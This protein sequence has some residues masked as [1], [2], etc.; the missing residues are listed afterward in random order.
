[1]RKMLWCSTCF[2]IMFVLAILIFSRGAEAQTPEKMLEKI[3][4]FGQSAVKIETGDNIIYIDPL[5]SEKTEDADIILITHS[6]S[7]H[8][9]LRS[10]E[11]VAKKETVF[12]ATKDCEGRIK[13]KFNAQVITLKPGMSKDLNGTLIEAVPAYNVAHPKTNNWV[14]YILTIDG[15]RIYHAG[16]TKR[17]PE[18]KEFTCDIAMLPLGQTYTMKSVEEAAEAAQDVKAKIAIPIHFGIYEG[19]IE[20]AHKFAELLKGKIQVVIKEKR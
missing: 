4:W 16:D 12:I 11:R 3:H 9:D 13:S 1:M 20:D 8:F 10:I 2:A 5:I 14:G 19:T 17:I 18:M 6:H 15:V 7:D